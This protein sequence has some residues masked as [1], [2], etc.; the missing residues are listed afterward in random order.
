MSLSRSAQRAIDEYESPDA[1]TRYDGVHRGRARHRREE[2]AIRRALRELPAGA[3]ILDLPCGTGR[4]FPVLHALGYRVTGADASAAMVGY[5]RDA[6]ERA[7]WAPPGGV[8]VASV[9]ETGFADGEFDAVLCNRLF[10][11]FAESE[12]RRAGLAELAR[13]CAGPVVVSFFC[14]RSLDAWRTQ[15]RRAHSDRRSGREAVSFQTFRADAEASGLEIVRVHR[16]LPGISQQWYC[17]ARR[18]AR[19]NAR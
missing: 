6:T 12:T 5:A 13:I 19:S 18:R 2:R 4:M 10:H 11:H 17:V 1:A 3:S 9:F 16:T 7:A 15:R 8:H 14:T